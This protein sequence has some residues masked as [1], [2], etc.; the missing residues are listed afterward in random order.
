RLLNVVA[1]LD[2]AKTSDPETDARLWTSGTEAFRPDPHDI[3][4]RDRAL[5]EELKERLPSSPRELT[6]GRA[7]ADLRLLQ[8][9]LRRKFFLERED[10]GWLEMFPY[11]RLESFLTQLHTCDIVDRDAM[12]R[13]VSNSEG[14]F[15]DPFA[16]DL[17]VRLVGENEGAERTF[18]IHDAED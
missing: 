2:V 1:T 6:T 17:A 12:V 11:D 18:V 8:A 14:L 15:N 10:P 4:R 13:A 3:E 9:S 5:L 16:Q 7:R